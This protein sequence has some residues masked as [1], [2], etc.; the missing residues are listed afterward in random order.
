[1]LIHGGEWQ[2]PHGS[3]LY[4]RTTIVGRYVC[5]KMW[6]TWL[7]FSGTDSCEKGFSNLE[8]SSREDFLL[9]KIVPRLARSI[10]TLSVVRTMGTIG[11]SVVVV[12][13]GLSVVPKNCPNIGAPDYRLL[14]QASRGWWEWSDLCRY[15]SDDN[16]D[17]L[18]YRLFRTSCAFLMPLSACAFWHSFL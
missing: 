5:Y 18:A 6:C 1:M 11:S 9:H 8:P 4:L 15:W 13:I 12:P 16:K 7:R 3:R 2:R 14:R 17:S 10:N